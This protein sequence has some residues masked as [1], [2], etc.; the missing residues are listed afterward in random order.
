MSNHLSATK[1]R[2]IIDKI[3]LVKHKTVHLKSA[4]FLQTAELGK[5]AEIDI[6]SDKEYELAWIGFVFSI[7]RGCLLLVTLF[8]TN[9]YFYFGVRKLALFCINAIRRGMLRFIPREMGENDREE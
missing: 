9:A 1:A 2:I 4:L 7:S 6:L 3:P 8:F 5:S